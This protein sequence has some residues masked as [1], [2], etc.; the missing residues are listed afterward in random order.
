MVIASLAWSLKAWLALLLPVRARH[1]EADEV[2]RRRVLRMEFRSLVQR[3]IMVPAQ[4]LHT[5]RTLVLR[6]LTWRPT[7][8]PLPLP[9]THS[10]DHACATHSCPHMPPARLVELTEPRSIYENPTDQTAQPDPRQPALA[11]AGMSLPQGQVEG[12]GYRLIED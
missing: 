2:D 7:S 3:L 11:P 5:G 8:R 9:P 10:D 4:V 1:R 6:L 12:L